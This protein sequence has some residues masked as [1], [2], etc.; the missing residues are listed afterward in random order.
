M[1]GKP[2]GWEL[3]YRSGPIP[4][5]EVPHEDA[6]ALHDSFRKQ[7][8]RRVLDPG[9]GD[10]RHLEYFTGPGCEVWGLDYARL[11]STWQGNSLAGMG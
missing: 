9:C 4:N 5:R 2:D 3:A 7:G 6:E 11:H 1:A 10:G 8:I